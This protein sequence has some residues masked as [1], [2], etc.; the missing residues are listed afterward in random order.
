[1]SSPITKRAFKAWLR[2]QDPNRTFQFIDP[3]GCIIAAFLKETTDMKCPSVGGSAYYR[4]AGVR[5]SPDIPMNKAG[6]V[7][8]DVAV[9]LASVFTVAQFMKAYTCRLY[10]ELQDV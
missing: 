9:C 3:E 1:M 4:D 8:A 6:E 2:K 5:G 10:P 7:I